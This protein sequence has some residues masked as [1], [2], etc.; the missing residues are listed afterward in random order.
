MLRVLTTV[1]ALFAMIGAARADDPCDDAGAC[2]RSDD[3]DT[4]LALDASLRVR[5]MHYDPTRFGLGGDADGYGLLRALASA[6]LRHGDWQGFVQLGVHGERGR[7][8]GPGGTDRG[9]LD[10]QQGYVTWQ[11]SRA[12]VQVGRQ[13]IGYGSARLLSVR[14]GP[15]IRLAFDGVRGAWQSGRMRVDLMALRPVDNRPGAFDDRRDEG[16]FLVGAYATRAP[17]RRGEPGIDAYVLGYGR[18]GARFAAAVGDERRTSFGVRVFGDDG[19]IDWNVEAVAQRGTLET[20]VGPPQDIRAWTIAT[21]TGI[22]WRGTRFSPRLGLKGDIAS[23]DRDPHDGRLQTFNALFPKAAYFSEASLLAPANLVDLQPS[24]TLQA[25]PRVTT[26]LGWQIAWKQHRNDAVY[27]TPTPLTP[28]PGSAGTSRRIGTQLKSETT[29]R[30]GPHVQWQLHLARIDAGP[31]LREAGG[32]DTVFA[33]IL[34][35]WTW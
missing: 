33:S 1:I 12:R 14:D 28:L 23:G 20:D 18:D 11:G 31:A 13:E 25:T 3:G 5:G 9:A 10:V 34:G 15:N 7:D 8:G 16:Q 30:A 27:V 2:L 26:L 22:T 21:D 32:R 17:A 24:L 29:W 6:D 19:R 35:T 4:R